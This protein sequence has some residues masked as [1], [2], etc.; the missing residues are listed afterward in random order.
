MPSRFYQTNLRSHSFNKKILKG[1]DFRNAD[2]R[3]VNFTDAVLTGAN[4]SKAK[5]GLNPTTVFAIGFIVTILIFLIGIAIGYGSAFPAF[6]SNLLAEKSNLGNSLLVIF[7]YVILTGFIVVFVR[8][9]LGASL[10]ILAIS[11]TVVTGIIGFAGTGDLLAAAWV[12]AILIAIAVA[13]VILGALA[14][15][16]LI[17][18]VGSKFLPIQGILTLYGVVLGTLEGIRKPPDMPGIPT[19]I[20]LAVTGVTAIVL[21]LLSLYIGVRGLG[22]DRRYKLIQ[23]LAI[24]LCT[25][26]GTKFQGADLTDAD[27]TEATLSYTDF[28]GAILKRTNWFEVNGLERSR[29][30]GTYLENTAIRELVISKNGQN[31]V[32]DHK[33]LRGLNLQNAILES[34]SF[35][36]ADVSESNLN[37]ADLTKSKLAKSQFY[38]TDLSNAC[39]TKACIQDWAI[40]TDTKLENIRCDEIY[41]RLPTKDDPD[42]WRK[43]DNRNEIFKQ[44]DFTDFIAPIIKT[45]DLYRQ[46]N[47]DPRQV[48]NAIKTLDIYYYGAIDS[49]AAAIALKKLAEENPEA[50]LEVVT[51]EGRGDKKIHLQAVITGKGNSSQL[52]ADY[53]V[54]YREILSL[55]AGE[56]Q[57]LLTLIAEKDERIYSLEKILA[58]TKEGNKVYYIQA[59]RDMSGVLNLDTISGNVTNATDPLST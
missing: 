58:T 48:G 6:I 42:P 31:C 10:G 47:V 19:P 56:V 33:N 41:M 21:L 15:A 38:A 23:T 22:G 14:V 26:F 9:G 57:T 16:I 59:G 27:F 53:A 46:Q 43:P 20:A 50:G 39:L 12:Q 1:E 30:E 34:A 17:A 28:R 54:K 51:L 49:A 8:Q 13:S 3:G 24:N 2:I 40:S 29:I 11:F 45:L 36:G 52:S 18:I 7:G 44:G 5:T 55:P 32:Y 37:S 25:T 35:V 4:F